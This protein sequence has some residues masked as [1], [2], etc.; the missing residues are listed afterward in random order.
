MRKI[1]LKKSVTDA[2]MYAPIRR[3]TGLTLA[4]PIMTTKELNSKAKWAVQ[5]RNIRPFRIVIGCVIL[6]WLRFL[7]RMTREVRKRTALAPYNRVSQEKA[8]QKAVVE[9]DITRD[10]GVEMRGG[11]QPQGSPSGYLIMWAS[12]HIVLGRVP[13]IFALIA[14]CKEIASEVYQYTRLAE[15]SRNCRLT[16]EFDAL[17]VVRPRASES[18]HDLFLDM[19]KRG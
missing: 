17:S 18:N 16:G 13:L 7:R 5:H 10:D 4:V 3:K 12:S 11:S 8:T 14:I 19:Y 1:P 6:F 2:R 9:S 15:T